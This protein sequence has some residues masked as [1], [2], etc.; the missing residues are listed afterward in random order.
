MPGLLYYPDALKLGRSEFR[1]AML[2]GEHPCL[3]VLDSFV[4][5][6]RIN[7]GQDLGYTHIPMEFVAGTRTGGR[8]S[9]FAR[10]FMPVMKPNTEFAAKWEL[11]CRAQVEEGI[12]D[13]ILAYEYL[14]RY[15]VQEGNK[16]VSVLKFCGADTVYAHVIRVLPE[17]GEASD[18]DE[19]L[20]GELVK[21]MRCSGVNYLELSKPGYDRLQLLMGKQPGERWSD[22]DRRDFSSLHYHFRKAYEAL[23]GNKLT[24]T[25]GDALLAFMEVYG[26]PAIRY[27]TGDQIK[28]MLGKAWEEITLQQ[29]AVA[30]DL[31]LDPD[32]EKKPGLLTQVLS[33]AEKKLKKAAFIHD[34]TCETYPWTKVH[35]NARVYAQQVLEG[36]VETTSYFGAMDGDPGEVLERA[37]A[38][39]NTIIFTTSSRLQPAALRCA[40]EHPNVIVLNCTQVSP[41]RYIRTY[42]L[43]SYEA[44]F[45]LGAIAGALAG[46]DRIGYTGYLCDTE[47]DPQMRRVLLA[48]HIADVNAFALG[49]QLVNPRATVYLEWYRFGALQDA[50]RSLT[51]KGIR[52]V[53]SQ[54]F[55]PDPEEG[56]GLCLFTDGV[57]VT[58]ASMVQNWGVCYETL[59]RRILDKSLQSEYHESGRAVNYYWGMSA[60]VVGV[61]CSE[62]LPDST[63]KLAELFRDNISR[64]LIRPFKGRIYSQS[65]RAMDGELSMEQ[66]IQMDWLAENIEGALPD[67]G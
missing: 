14:N 61:D 19:A 33:I 59:L 17:P 10:N 66:I 49:A 55:L 30:N 31:K 23:G 57:P 62:K 43:R 26:Y 54:D 63:R 8:T 15:Y 36:A 21:F 44:K 29:E 27:S 47:E 18:Q 65:S 48:A 42:F 20:Y 41:H 5:D 67:M 11:L 24:T 53:S 6:G 13:P 51:G 58:M 34:G 56:F 22:E 12:R 32:E 40:V 28:E 45:V 1:A 39:G 7:R 35:E 25:R 46:S 16:R 60:G 3:P 52:L 38:D 50:V 37:V 64:G 9:A 2:K 4:P